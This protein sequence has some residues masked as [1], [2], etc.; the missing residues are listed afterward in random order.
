METDA[1]KTE[2]ELYECHNLKCLEK[3]EALPTTEGEIF[4]P[5]CGSADN[6]PVEEKSQEDKRA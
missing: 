4:C 2:I 3:F 6:Y 5:Y 1:K